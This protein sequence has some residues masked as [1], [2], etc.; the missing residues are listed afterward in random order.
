[1]ALI[2]PPEGP[3]T[4]HFTWHEAACR[5][6][7]LIPSIAS[8]RKTAAW[9]EQVRAALGNRVVHVNSWCRCPE[10]NARIGGAPNSY[11]LRGMAV[12]I[13]VRD[14]S[15]RKVQ[16]ILKNLPLIGGLGRYASFTHV[17]RGPVRQWR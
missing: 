10:H 11:H 5:H 1:M 7:G 16:A 14:L 17:D 13:T 15:P 8:V 2:R 6:C 4:E 12:D 3:L 9:M